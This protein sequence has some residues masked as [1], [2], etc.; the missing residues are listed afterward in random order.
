M[1]NQKT[2]IVVSRFDNHSRYQV[3]VN[4]TVPI[5]YQSLQGALD[6]VFNYYDHNNA[7]ISI[8]TRGIKS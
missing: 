3:I 5:I 1:E 6:W 2:K 8:D 4:D 7:F